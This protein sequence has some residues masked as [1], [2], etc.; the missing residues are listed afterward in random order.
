MVDYGA[1]MR[2]AGNRDTS[3]TGEV[4]MRVSETPGGW[5]DRV[6]GMIFAGLSR[7]CVRR[8]E[9]IE[10][11]ELG[12]KRQLMLVVCDGQRYLVGA[13][14]DGIHA[15]TGVGTEPGHSPSTAQDASC[16]E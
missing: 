13:G 2:L 5:F 3:V 16:K 8:M 7:T 10:K 15:I 12:G 1:A 11:L 9:L 4:A 14:S 6:K